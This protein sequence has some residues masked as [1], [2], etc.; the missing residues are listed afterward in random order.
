VYDATFQAYL[1]LHPA[2]SGVL[3]A[4]G[5]GAPPVEAAVG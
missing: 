1:G 3:T 2:I 5:A 4:A